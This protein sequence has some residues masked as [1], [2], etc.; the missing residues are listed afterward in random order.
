MPIVPELHARIF[1]AVSQPGVYD[2]SGNQVIPQALGMDAWHTCEYTHCRAGWVVVL[3]GEAICELR[4]EN[5]GD[6]LRF[7]MRSCGTCGE[8]SPRYR[9]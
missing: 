7:D 8:P 4:C 1:A 6:G 5:C 9:Q 2:A 3:A